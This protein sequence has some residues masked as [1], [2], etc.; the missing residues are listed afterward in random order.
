MDGL[1]TQR[2]GFRRLALSAAKPN[3]P[4]PHGMQTAGFGDGRMLGFAGQPTNVRLPLAPARVPR[5]RSLL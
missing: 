4:E 3:T 5:L 1:P 2:S